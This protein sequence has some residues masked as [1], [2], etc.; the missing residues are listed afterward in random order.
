MCCEATLAGESAATLVTLKSFLTTVNE[1]VSFKG[2]LPWEQLGTDLA[3]EPLLADT[4]HGGGEAGEVLVLQNGHAGDSC[5]ALLSVDK[6]V[7][8]EVCLL[9]Q[10]GAALLTGKLL[11]P[12]MHDHVGDVVFVGKLLATFLTAEHGLY[13]WGQHRVSG[14][15]IWMALKTRCQLLRGLA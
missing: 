9:R 12:A 14:R 15:C 7:G 11:L 6:H 3:G 1:A 10:E 5:D 13:V 4:G 8:A 2:T